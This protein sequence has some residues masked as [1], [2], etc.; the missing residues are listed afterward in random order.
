MRNSFSQEQAK[1]L[2]VIALI[3]K[4]SLQQFQTREQ[5]KQEIR[6]YRVN[7]ALFSFYKKSTYQIIIGLT[8]CKTETVTD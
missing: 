3:R 5:R 1:A 8:V 7:P 6:N 4:K 2:R